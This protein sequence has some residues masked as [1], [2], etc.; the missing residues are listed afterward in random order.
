MHEDMRSNFG[1]VFEQT[2]SNNIYFEHIYPFTLNDRALFSEMFTVFNA[3][4]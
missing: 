3:V 1:L 4:K 2:A